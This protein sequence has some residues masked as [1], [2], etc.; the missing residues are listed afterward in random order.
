MKSLRQYLLYVTAA[1]LWIAV[2][3]ILPD[4]LDNPI[5]GLQ[6]ILTIAIYVVALSIISFLIL[7]ITSLNKY[8][9]T[10]FIPLYGLLGATT[11][12]YRILYH[13]TI[14]PLIL[15]CIFHTNIE[16][17][18]GVIS[19]PL[20]L[21]GLFNILIGIAF[22]LWRWKI[23]SPRPILVHALVAI[24]LMIGYYNF[25][26]RLHQSINQRYPMHL[27]KSLQQYL[28]VQDQRQKPH[29]IPQYS[30]IQKTDTLNIVVV[31][32]E[33][34]RADHLSINGYKKPTTPLL[35]KRPNVISLSN[36]YSEQTHTL[37]SLPILLTR[38]DS[39]HPEYQFTET[40]FAAI[41]RKEGFYTAWISNQDL[42]ETFA[43]FPSECDTTV[44]VNA[45]KSVFVFSGWY[46][47]ELLPKMDEQLK[48]GY[49]KN[50]FIIHMIGSHW[51][52]NNHVPDSLHYFSPVTCNRVVT[53]NTPEQ[54]INSY[55]NTIRYTDL[56]LD[57][58]IQR[59]DDQ[60][61]IL[62]YISDHGESLGEN[63]YWLHA[64][65]AEETKKP[66][67]IIW[68]SEGFEKQYPQKIAA[69]K[70]NQ[71]KHYRTDFLFHSIL[72][73]ADIKIEDKTSQK[74]NVFTNLSNE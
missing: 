28:W 57:S 24:C 61:A 68:Y 3:V 46:D 50:L 27:V 19:W 20:L 25:N 5:T 37:A 39:L 74:L 41:L 16:E 63:G 60:C 9:A 2:G 55:D 52:Y 58:I 10:V 62:V 6:G 48:L 43:T 40:S 67:C 70:K 29:T 54:I 73:I 18:I 30:V 11:A 15:D 1:T 65:G 45:G 35:Q 38:A 34:A 12:Y 33:S 36:I 7:Y 59:I 17:A 71:Q 47:Q 53:S 56:I 13:V 4:F 23:S 8:I 42:G 51:Y 31:I 21:W 22:I 66:A 14:T 64:A 26:S 72:S 32:G 49:D 44:W 69:L